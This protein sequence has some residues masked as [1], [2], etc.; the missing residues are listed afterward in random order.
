MIIRHISHLIRMF[1]VLEVQEVSV[2]EVG[3][4]LSPNSNLSM[5]PQTREAGENILDG[6]L[7][8][9]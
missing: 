9:G 4:F 1:F 2:S 7:N 6:K 8:V 3:F 5:T